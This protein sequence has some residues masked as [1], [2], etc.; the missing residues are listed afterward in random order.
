MIKQYLRKEKLEED[1]NSPNR[2]FL[3]KSKLVL[4]L[5]LLVSKFI[6]LTNLLIDHVRSFICDQESRSTKNKW[7]LKD[8]KILVK[9]NFFTTESIF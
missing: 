9:S 4:L 7:N 8:L 5:L 2:F 3:F 1:Q 6:R